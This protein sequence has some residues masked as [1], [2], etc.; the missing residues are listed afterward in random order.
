MPPNVPK[1]AAAILAGGLASRYG[2]TDKGLLDC[3]DGRSIIRRLLDE[4][5]AAGLREAII[6]AN[7]A[8][9]YADLG[10]AVVPDLR[11]GAGPLGGIEAA[12]S[13]W[14]GR[15]EATV[16]LPC[17]L[18]GISAGEIRALAETFGT[19]GAPLVVAETG[20]ARWHP[21]CAV[22]RNDLLPAVSAA[23]DQ[24]ELGVG[25]L[26][27]KLGAVGVRF[28]DEAPFFNVNTPEDLTAWR[29]R[30]GKGATDD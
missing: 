16:L 27:R 9:R 28:E 4:L 26:W 19:R 29:R 10:V 14:A 17:D 21:L 22:V 2:G 25:R 20:E 3:G 7:D 24:G 15:A 8:P 23:I 1:L 30:S 5:A 11:R 6:C 12:M 18:P 13:Y